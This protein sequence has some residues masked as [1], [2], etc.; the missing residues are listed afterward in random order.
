MSGL[1]HPWDGIR[2]SSET[3]LLKVYGLSPI[4]T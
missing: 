2:H 4:N 3:V 1:P